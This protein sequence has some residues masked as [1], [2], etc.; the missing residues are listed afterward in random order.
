MLQWKVMFLFF[1]GQRNPN[2]HIVVQPGLIKV[3]ANIVYGYATYVSHFFP[4]AYFIS[5][6]ILFCLI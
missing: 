1:F 6:V 3:T 4:L 5:W 2:D